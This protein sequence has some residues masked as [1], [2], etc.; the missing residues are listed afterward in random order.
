MQ[1]QRL[2]G[3]LQLSK[4][5]SVDT[6][7]LT[8]SFGWEGSEVFQQQDVQELCHVFFDALEQ[9]FK[10]TE[11]ENII[12]DLYAGELIDYVECVDVDYKS[13]RRDKF[14]DFSVAIKPFG[15]NHAMHSL[16]DCI[17]YYLQPEL[18]DGDNKYY[19]EKYD[20]KVDAIK[21]LKFNKLPKI[22]SVQLKR[23]VYESQGSYVTQK[24]LNDQ[25]RFPMILN[26]NKYVVRGGGEDSLI[27]AVPDKISPHG[28]ETGNGAEDKDSFE[29][30]LSERIRLLQEK[31]HTAALN[32]HAGITSSPSEMDVDFEDMTVPDLVHYDGTKAADQLAEDARLF[33]EE[34]PSPDPMELIRRGPWVYELYAVLI[35]A[36]VI[37]GGHYYAYIRDLDTRRWWNF[38]D[39]NVTE[40]SESQVREAW[41]GRIKKYNVNN[42]SNSVSTGAIYTCDTHT[43]STANAYMLMYHKVCP[44]SNKTVKFPSDDLVPQYI[45]DDV[46]QLEEEAAKR[47]LAEQERDNRLELRVIFNDLEFVIQTSKKKTLSELMVQVWSECN[48]A[49]FLKVDSDMIQHNLYSFIR[50]RNYHSYYKTPLE[51]YDIDIHFN[52]KLLD[53]RFFDSKILYLD[54]RFSV[55]TEWEKYDNDG[56]TVLLVEYDASID[57]FKPTRYVRMNKG[58]T[59]ADLRKAASK[60]VQYDLMNIRFLKLADGTDGEA[61]AEELIGEYSRLRDDLWLYDMQKVFVEEKI[62]S[63]FDSPAKRAYTTQMNKINLKVSAPDSFV[64]D[65]VVQADRRWTIQQLREAVGKALGL[66]GVEFRMHRQNHTGQE[67]KDSCQTIR[68]QSLFNEAHIATSLGQPLKHDQFYIQIQLYRS[69]YRTGVTEL[70]GAEGYEYTCPGAEMVELD[71][72]A[73]VSAESKPAEVVYVTE[74]TV[75]GADVAHYPDSKPLEAYTWDPYLGAAETVPADPEC[76]D[77]LVGI[78]ETTA[79]VVGVAIDD[80]LPPLQSKNALADTGSKFGEIKVMTGVASA[81]IVALFQVVVQQDMPVEELRQVVADKLREGEYLPSDAPSSMVR[82]RERQSQQAGRILRDGK[83]FRQSD[84]SP[85]DGKIFI[86]QVLDVPE[87]LL[88]NKD[89]NIVVLMQ[90][91]DRQTWS[92]GPVR[93]VFIRGTDVVKDISAN[94]ARMFRIPPSNLRVLLLS[95]HTEVLLCDLHKTYPTPSRNW[96][97][98]TRELKQMNQM[99]WH[100][101]DGDLIIVQDVH[102]PL[103]SLSTAEQESVARVQSSS[104]QGALSTNGSYNYSH[105]GMGSSMTSFNYW[106]S[107]SSTLGNDVGQTPAVL[108]NSGGNGIR[109]KTFKDRQRESQ[110]DSGT[111]ENKADEEVAATVESF[112]NTQDGL[113]DGALNEMNGEWRARSDD[114]VYG[115]SVGKGLALFDDI[116]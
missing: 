47:I 9:T 27:S 85:Y 100:L 12:D 113:L 19:A 51:V 56:S 39:S 17:E 96:H 15:F 3:K 42:T 114:R 108:V 31:R 48:V 92:L 87:H 53:M 4:Q 111:A 60:F 7:A 74:A 67:L 36:G 37:S 54:Y 81:H 29:A 79:S 10:G 20:K 112:D 16:T 102:E 13:E 80:T 22:L 46:R 83:T 35:H 69:P 107:S 59:V 58:A 77:E 52:D 82:L 75:V 89:G 109:I 105:Y 94:I 21:G 50:L 76:L 88:E 62:G 84:A 28:K 43:M 25:V 23:F 73:V 55:D 72:E 11:V 90:R 32:T 116:C 97:D 115:S 70:C 33:P 5:M 18:M 66:E 98:P 103:K 104:Q 14:I 86:A 30:F 64:F 63:L 61:R 41:G 44:D 6:I 93:E 2:F 34:M 40:I 71:M 26:M 106:N 101:A 38:N 95:A 8:K 1:L 49:A 68:S 91:W 57:D 45:K 99:T 78:T 110:L 24:K 65:T